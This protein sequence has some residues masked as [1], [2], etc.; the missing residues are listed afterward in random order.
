MHRYAHHAR[1]RVTHG[2]ASFK[3]RRQCSH[4]LSYKL[5]TQHLRLSSS[6]CLQVSVQSMQ[7]V[8]DAFTRINAT[9]LPFVAN[10]PQ[11]QTFTPYSQLTNKQRANITNAAYNLAAQVMAAAAILKA[12]KVWLCLLPLHALSLLLVCEVA[13]CSTASSTRPMHLWD[14]HRPVMSSEVGCLWRWRLQQRLACSTLC[15]KDL[16]MCKILDWIV[17]APLTS[18]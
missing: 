3:K 7:A 8:T 18:L 4:L 5:L 2:W 16:Y 14:R 6:L 17:P 15:K 1:S 10:S 11:G 12:D 13:A 9:L